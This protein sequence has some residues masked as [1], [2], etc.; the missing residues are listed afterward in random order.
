MVDVI[1]VGGGMVG[2]LGDRF[3]RVAVVY[4]VYNGLIVLS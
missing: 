3:T 4:V 1:I 2:G